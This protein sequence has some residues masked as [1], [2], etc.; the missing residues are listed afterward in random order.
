MLELSR[1]FLAITCGILIAGCAARPV[2]NPRA[3]VTALST[4]TLL[5]ESDG[6]LKW[7]GCRIEISNLVRD[8]KRHPPKHL[9]IEG[10][11]DTRFEVISPVLETLRRHRLLP[12]GVIG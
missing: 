6:T 5:V 1:N 8:L 7:R 9:R 2:A 4:E 10:A 3:Q 11:A 12:E